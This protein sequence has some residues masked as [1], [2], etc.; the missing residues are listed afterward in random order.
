MKLKDLVRGREAKRILQYLL[1]T[2]EEEGE[3]KEFEVVGYYKENGWFYCF[4]NSY[5]N[6][7]VEQT[8]SLIIARKWCYGLADLDEMY[9]SGWN[10]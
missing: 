4:D 1:D 9:P 8:R 2:Y 3:Y 6:C 7:Y 10:D 5:N